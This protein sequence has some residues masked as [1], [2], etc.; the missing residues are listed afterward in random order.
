M[1]REFIF[2]LIKGYIKVAIY[3]VKGT[4]LD[5]W[6]IQTEENIEDNGM[7]AYNTE[8]VFLNIKIIK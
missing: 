7:M 5:L 6:N 3:M 1:V 8:M 2:G 4:D